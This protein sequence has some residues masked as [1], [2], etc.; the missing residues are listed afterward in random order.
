MRTT[1]DQVSFDL[2][3][4]R[5]SLGGKQLALQDKTW[6][7]LTLLASRAPAVVTR[8]EIIDQIWQGNFLIGEK[9]L[10]Q[11]L[12]AI[13]DALSD[14]ARNP[15]YVQTLPRIGY[16]WLQRPLHEKIPLWSRPAIRALAAGITTLA[17]VF[18]ASPLNDRKLFSL[19]EQCDPT[20]QEEV[21]A[22][23]SSG[24]LF[25][26]FSAGCRLIV[27][28]SGAKRFGEPLVSIDGRSVAFAVFEDQSCRLVTLALQDGEHNDF[29][30]CPT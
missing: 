28:P 11:A 9:G 1:N 4:R 2:Q 25:I 29:G 15:R 26:D 27:R 6:Q 8:Q 23:R 14:D 24:R 3:Q 21:R 19:P 7:V 12:W 18:T 22:Y 5:V 30:E 20:S 16:R 17:L 13:R 10:N